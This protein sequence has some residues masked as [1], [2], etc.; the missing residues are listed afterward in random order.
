MNQLRP[1]NC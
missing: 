1:S